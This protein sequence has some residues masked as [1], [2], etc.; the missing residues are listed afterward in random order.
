[1]LCKI[2][3][4]YVYMYIVVERSN[5]FSLSKC[6]FFCVAVVLMLTALES[7]LILIN[8]FNLYI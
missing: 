8:I 2:L 5:F 1:M 4:M 3:Y 7:R 6:Y